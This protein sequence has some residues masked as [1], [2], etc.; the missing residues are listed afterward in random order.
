M[1]PETQRALIARTARH[2]EDGTTA[3]ADA[4]FRNPVSSYTS[5]ERLARERATL[6]QGRPHLLGLSALVPEPGSW[7][8]D[9]TTGTPLLLVRDKGGEL[10]G[11]MNVCRHR[12][13]RVAGGCGVSKGRL[14]CPY[15]AWSYALDGSLAHVPHDEGF[16]DLVRDD[17]GLR[18]IAVAERDGLVWVRPGSTEPI[19]VDAHLAGLAPELA[20]YGFGS[21]HHFRTETLRPALNWK[22][23][24]DTFMEAYHL[25]ALHQQTVGPIFYGNLSL[26]DVFGPHHRM[27][28]VRKTFPELL[29]QP[30]AERDYLKHTIELYTL[31]PACVFV[32]QKD[33]L[34]VWRMFPDGERVDAAVV[35]LA[36]YTPE[37][38]TTEKAVRYWEA[39]IRL[40]IAAVDQE[41]FR[42][43][44]GIQRNLASG[45]QNHVVYGRNEPA[46]I[47]FHRSLARALGEE[48]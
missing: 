4:V 21:W 25:H 44:E 42:L 2:L 15:H 37:P 35:E 28:A 22:I 47:H 26:S 18:P 3:M 10:R 9:D 17:Y 46:L 41:D 45:A 6:F 30:E 27:I 48:G 12:G 1:Q 14:T 24:V 23:A 32:H 36:L 40:A 34:E 8:S 20:S 5:T 19:D 11:F 38:A 33:H 13:A 16:P 31:F 29:A 7:R 39:N 43:G